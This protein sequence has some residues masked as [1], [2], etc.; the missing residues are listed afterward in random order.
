MGSEPTLA[1][2]IAEMVSLF[3]EVRRV[4]RDDGTFWLNVGDSYARNP[5]KGT[6]GTPNGRNT[7]AMGYSGGAGLPDNAKEKDLL[8]V[9]ARLAIA[10]CDD[11]W[12]L[13][14]DIIWHKPN[15]MPE[16]VTDRCTKSHEHIFML[17][18]KPRYFFDAEAVK[19]AAV[20]PAGTKGAKGS[21]ARFETPGVNSRPPEYAVYDGT[22]NL[23]DV[24][25]F[26]TKPF[27]GAHF[28]TFP[29]ELPERCIKAGTSEK[30]CCPSCGLP[31]ERVVERAKPPSVE[32][33]DLDRFGTGDAGTHRKVG[34]QYQKWLD[35]NPAK[36]TGW[37][38]TCACQSADPVP[39][40]VLDPFG[41]AG[42]TA[43]VAERLGRNAVLIE[44]NPDY[45][46]MAR[47][48]I[49]AACDALTWIDMR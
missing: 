39:C 29:P 46:A 5:S 48:R 32:P 8:M 17:T 25:T 34:G 16:S 28:A 27:K 2:Y 43:L 6:T 37:R 23:R 1:E 33:S 30:G 38:Q 9:P 19:E 18:K 42:T 12:Y 4:L 26:S 3:R 7:A 31:W 11:G 21:K 44:L 47:E 10:L 35:A 45:A 36:T 15:P 14:Q 20:T 13:R 24:W 49:V 40:T 41:G 22:R